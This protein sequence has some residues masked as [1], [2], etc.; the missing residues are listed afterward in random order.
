[1][2]DKAALL[3]EL[4]IDRNAPAPAAS[5]SMFRVLSIILLIGV[6]ALLAWI[7]LW[8]QAGQ[9]MPG[10][11]PGSGANTSDNGINVKTAVARLGNAQAAGD[12]VLDATGYVVARRQATVS[13]KATGKVVEVFH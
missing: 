11:G 6:L 1:M 13:S 7:F 2:S 3:N 4:K 10:G 9:S 8:P 12:S 5:G